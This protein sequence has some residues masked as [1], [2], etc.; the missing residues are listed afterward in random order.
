MTELLKPPHNISKHPS[1][2]QCANNTK[3]TRPKYQN[4]SKC[5]NSSKRSKN[6]QHLETP[7]HIGTHKQHKMNQAEIPE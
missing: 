3:W 5:L 1:I 2:S 6:P 7:E 4:S